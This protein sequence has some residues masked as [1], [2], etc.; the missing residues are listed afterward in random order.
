VFE[1]LGWLPTFPL[2]GFL[3][4]F[5]SGGGLPKKLVAVI[6]AGSIGLAFCAAVLV[7]LPIINGDAQV[8]VHEVYTWMAVGSFDAAFGLYLDGLSVVMILVITGVGF[9]I[10]LYSTGFMIDDPSYSR[11]VSIMNGVV[12]GFRGVVVAGYILIL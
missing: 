2:L 8:I 3:T 9:L 11:V 10:H 4:L 6:G 1:S 12:G 7:S 5:L